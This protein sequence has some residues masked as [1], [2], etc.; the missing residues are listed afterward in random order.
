[1][2]FRCVKPPTSFACDVNFIIIITVIINNNDNS[3]D[4]VASSNVYFHKLYKYCVHRSNFIHG[5]TAV[6]RHCRHR[7]CKI[8]GIF[9]AN[10]RCLIILIRIARLLHYYFFLR[11][12]FKLYLMN[13][14]NIIKM[15]IFYKHK[16]RIGMTMINI[17]SGLQ[18]A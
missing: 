8:N 4:N 10:V 15:N 11:L 1:M 2:V 9:R 12:L 13:R 16:T 6:L 7:Y 5:M 3:T 17:R 18:T 14:I